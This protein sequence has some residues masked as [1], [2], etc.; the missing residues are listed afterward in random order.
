ME[1]LVILL[2]YMIGCIS[3]GYYLTRFFA[4]KDIRS[5]GS[6]ST[7]AM[8]VGRTL[9]KKGFIIT[10]CCDF[11]KGM[12]ALIIANILQLPIWA[13]MLSLL[14]VVIGHIY[15]AQLGFR[16]GKG[17]ATAFGAL[18]VFNWHLLVAITVVFLL[19]FVLSKK[20][21]LSGIL[22]IIV[23][24]IMAVLKK[25]SIIEITGLMILV[26]IILFAHR[27]NI[28]K[29]ILIMRASANVTSSGNNNKYRKG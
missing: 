7:G 13:I 10:V 1:I 24:P 6:G 28:Y 8:N 20:Y 25:H 12:I 11:S 29:L 22:A 18:F 27:A 23:L 4:D 2:S 19:C 17:I 15:P 14:G 21:M 9:G 26:L 16:G 5:C 3:V